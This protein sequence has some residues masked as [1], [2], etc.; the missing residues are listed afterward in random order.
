MHWAATASLAHHSQSVTRE[1]W[2]R[3]PPARCAGCT[4]ARVRSWR[5][6]GGWRGPSGGGTIYSGGGFDTSI[7]TQGCKHCLCTPHVQANRL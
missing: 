5:K 6:P 7:R 4:T 3:V 2:G 1:V